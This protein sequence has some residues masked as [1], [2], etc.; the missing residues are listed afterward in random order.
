MSL[1]QYINASTLFFYQIF[2]YITLYL[3]K[4]LN[5]SKVIIPLQFFFQNFARLIV[6][7]NFLV[8]VISFGLIYKIDVESYPAFALCNGQAYRNFFTTSYLGKWSCIICHQKFFDNT[9]YSW[10]FNKGVYF[11]WYH[12][13]FQQKIKLLLNFCVWKCELWNLAKIVFLYS[14]KSNKSQINFFL[15]I[16]CSCGFLRVHLGSFGFNAQRFF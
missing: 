7:C 10:A 5:S 13:I 14:Q 9:I 11:F 4:N 3:S 12:E 16:I 15:E 2:T 6:F 1:P 8:P